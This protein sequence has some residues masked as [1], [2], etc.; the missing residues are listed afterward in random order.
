MA[1]HVKILYNL[2]SYL[3]KDFKTVSH[4]AQKGN[5]FIIVQDEWTDSQEGHSVKN[6]QKYI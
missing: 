4:N 3:P 2:L 6:T 1:V 5:T